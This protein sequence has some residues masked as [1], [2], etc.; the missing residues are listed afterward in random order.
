MDPILLSPALQEVYA[1]SSPEKGS[2]SA[3]AL[4]SLPSAAAFP[5]C[6]RANAMPISNTLDSLRKERRHEDT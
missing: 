2:T 6:G 3:S 5:G 4:F 1:A